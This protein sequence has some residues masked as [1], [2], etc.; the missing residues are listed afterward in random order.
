MT[1]NVS[2]KCELQI[3]EHFHILAEYEEF[4]NEH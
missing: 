4:I 3:G 2:G 1:T